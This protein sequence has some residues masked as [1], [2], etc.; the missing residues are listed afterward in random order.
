LNKK[1]ELA[2]TA[3]NVVFCP[4]VMHK[5]PP[6]R[7]AGEIFRHLATVSCDRGGSHWTAN[8]SS[9]NS[10]RCDKSGER[11]QAPIS[12]FTT[13]HKCSISS[14]GPTLSA[15]TRSFGQHLIAL[16]WLRRA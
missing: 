8:R 12:R 7:E 1:P 4:F 3:N 11:V 6:G 10:S 15:D 14:R 2:A 13:W 5:T 9:L 16:A